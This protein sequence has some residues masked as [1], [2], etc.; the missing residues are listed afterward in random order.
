ML[1]SRII[2]F[3][4]VLFLVV[5]LLLVAFTPYIA[6]SDLG[7]ARS[8]YSAFG[9][10]CHQKISRSTCLFDGNGFSIGDC[11]NQTGEYV[12]NDRANISEARDGT[13][14][15]KFPVCSRDIGL[16]LFML[17]GALTYPFVFRLDEKEI[18]PPILL[19]LAIVPLAL[20]GTIQLL[21]DIGI[22]PFA[23][24][25]T[26]FTRLWTGAIAG[27]V[28]SFFVI[29]VLNKMFNNEPKIKSH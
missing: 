10:F 16:Y 19:I 28:A 14:G 6:F 8:L 26:N 29:P 9:P 22:V 20:D 12:A 7:F 3:A 21:S 18:L 5:F 23:Y 15:Y 17:I 2:Y 4:Y 1:V 27:F 24:E 11:T 13:V 25:S